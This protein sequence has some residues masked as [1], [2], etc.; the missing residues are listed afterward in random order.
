MSELSV[1]STSPSACPHLNSTI[2]QPRSAWRS[3]AVICGEELLSG[4]LIHW[5]DASGDETRLSGPTHNGAAIGVAA[6]TGVALNGGDGPIRSHTLHDTGVHSLRPLPREI[7]E[8]DI[9]RAIVP[10]K[11]LGGGRLLVAVQESGAGRR[12]IKSH[13]RLPE[14][15]PEVGHAPGIGLPADFPAIVGGVV[16]HP[17]AAGG[18]LRN[19]DLAGGG[20]ENG[21]QRLFLP[22]I[23]RA[24][25]SI[26]R[27]T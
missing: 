8:D 11:D 22:I 26:V 27:K 10:L 7:E 20:E 24:D 19:A 25:L 14:D 9:P 13:P 23:L 1:S 16:L 2:K 6:G 17:I 21:A 5:P 4:L 3:G 15:P 18:A 12:L